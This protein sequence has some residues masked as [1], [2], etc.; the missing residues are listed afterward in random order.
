ML[1]LVLSL[2]Q[3]QAFSMDSLLSHLYF[4]AEELGARIT[5]CQKKNEVLCFD[6]ELFLLLSL[7]FPLTSSS[8][9]PVPPSPS[10]LLPHLPSLL[11]HLL[12]LLF[13]LF[14]LSL[15]LDF[16]LLLLLFLPPASPSLHPPVSFSSL[17]SPPPPDFSSVLPSASSS[18]L[19]PSHASSF[20]HSHTCF[21][22]CQEILLYPDF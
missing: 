4:S 15:P 16:L 17:P 10:S 18:S 9:P 8:L 21:A 7:V 11:I 1:K 5:Q 19:S 14:P 13:L 22:Y 2:S 20:K 3:T 6:A 12:L